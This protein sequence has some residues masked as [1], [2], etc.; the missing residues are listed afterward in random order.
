MERRSFL[1]LEQ[2]LQQFFSFYSTL[3][4]SYYDLSPWTGRLDSKASGSIPFSILDPFEH[5]HN[6]S[7]NISDANWLKFQE[8]C[9]LANQILAEAARKR[10][11]KSWGLSLLLTRKSL[12]PKNFHP[13]KQHR[14]STSHSI[15]WIS[16]A[17]N[18]EEL[19]RKIQHIF[20][21]ILLFEPIN[22]ETIR[23]KRPASPDSG[24][25]TPNS[26]A[27]QFDDTL[28]AKRRR[29][30]DDGH[31]LTPVMDS[32]DEK[33]VSAKEKTFHQVDFKT[34]IY[35]STPSLLSL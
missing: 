24:E 35:R 23:K 7:A 31:A 18:E 28:S 17:T 11:H 15:E 19:D 5:E 3:S 13:E 14:P 8:E 6:L 34:D 16:H 25:V 21:D 2:L 30:D 29:I 26:L 20:K 27:E 1:D 10:Q 22:A 4:G 33:S 9:T 32:D 12:P